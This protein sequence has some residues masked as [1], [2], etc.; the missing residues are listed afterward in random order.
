MSNSTISYYFTHEKTGIKVIPKDWTH[1]YVLQSSSQYSMSEEL[2][3]HRS[4]RFVTYEEW[5]TRNRFWSGAVGFQKI[6]ELHYRG[7]PPASFMDGIR[8]FLRELYNHACMRGDA[9]VA[10]NASLAEKQ[11][12]VKSSGYNG[13]HTRL[14][15]Y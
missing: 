3:I 8:F 12:Y 7:I 5:Q 13:V 6:G 1:F 4:N 2:N 9:E 11:F 14:L 15:T 10:Y